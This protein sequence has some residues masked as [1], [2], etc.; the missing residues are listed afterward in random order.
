MS[1]L[2]PAQRFAASVQPKTS[3]VNPK[4]QQRQQFA[5][6]AFAVD[7]AVSATATTAK[8]SWI[9]FLMTLALLLLVLM[10]VWQWGQ[11]LQQSW[12][13]S[14][15][16]AL[17]PSLLS[18]VLLSLLVI[19]SWREWRL[20]R[21][22]KLN[23]Q[24]QQQ[25]AR[26]AQSVQF[27]EARGLCEGILQ[28]MPENNV[29]D[30]AAQWRQA[31]TPEHS[32]QEQLQLFDRLVLSTVDKKAQQLIWRASTDSSLA[33]AISPFALADMVLVIWRS[34]RMLRELAELYGA[35]VGQLRSLA[36]LKRAL[37]ALLWAGGSE[38]ALDMAG[39]LLSS[40]LTARLS[41]RAGQGII[42]GLLVARLGYLAQQQLRPL[43]L[44]AAQKLNFS[45]LSKALVSRFTAAPATDNKN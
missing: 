25:A 12:Q 8:R 20:W 38:L 6:N 34:S 10:G 41:A 28:V 5:D 13:Q 1:E 11:W 18:V 19:V 37:A 30:V 26:I 32:D 24:W 42:A 22:L 31:V 23:Q 36:M 27:G 17:L 33:V 21:R 43:P 44:N 3:T 7:V 39:D 16:S 15:L 4:L 2:K 45:D 14:I 9:G 29:V 35:P 40:E